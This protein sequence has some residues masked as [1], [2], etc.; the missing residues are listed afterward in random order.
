MPSDTLQV[1]LG[2][3]ARSGE[4]WTLS[5]GGVTFSLKAIK[6]LAYLQ[7]LLQHPGEEFHATDLVCGPGVEASAE[8]SIADAASPSSGLSVGGLGDAAEMLDQQPSRSTKGGCANS[9]KNSKSCA[10]VAILREARR[11]K[12]KLTSLSASS[13]ER[14]VWEGAIDAPAPPPSGRA[15]A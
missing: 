8:H 1:R 13:S 14:W 4:F 3:F 9:E 10:D 15:S 12:R 2:I 11:S 5:Y 7:F 6:G